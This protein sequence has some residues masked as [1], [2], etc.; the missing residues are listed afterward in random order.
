MLCCYLPSQLH[1]CLL[2]LALP[3]PALPCF[4]FSYLS[5]FFINSPGG[6][7]ERLPSSFHVLQ[8]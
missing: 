4:S 7:M 8:L 3:C 2:C 1:A 6:R 5:L